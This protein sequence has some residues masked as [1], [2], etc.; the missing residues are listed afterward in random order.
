MVR[1]AV[2]Q[3][4]DHRQIGKGKDG[5]KKHRHTEDRRHDGQVDLKQRAPESGTVN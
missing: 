1:A 2:G 3:Q 4:V 5:P